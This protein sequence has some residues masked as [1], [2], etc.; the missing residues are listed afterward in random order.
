MQQKTGQNLLEKLHAHR[1]ARTASSE[2][3]TIQPEAREDS[4]L[5][6]RTPGMTWQKELEAKTREARAAIR[7]YG[8]VLEAVIHDNVA[9]RSQLFGV[10]ERVKILEESGGL[11]ARELCT[12]ARKLLGD[13]E[14]RAAKWDEE[15]KARE[16][17]AYRLR[18]LIMVAAAGLVVTG[19]GLGSLVTGLVFWSWLG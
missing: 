1:L 5:P 10:H 9:R 7:E 14:Q 18:A 19:A 15:Q 12:Q 17:R 11:E 4:S 8:E 16:V 13:L 3:P 2:H 6:K